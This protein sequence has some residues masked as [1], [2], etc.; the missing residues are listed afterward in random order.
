MFMQFMRWNKT[1]KCRFGIGFGDNFLLFAIAAA[2]WLAWPMYGSAANAGK[3]AP[4]IT[5][6]DWLNSRPLNA[7][8]LKGRVLLVEF[9]TYG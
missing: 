4:E 9:W 7:A 6:A 2:T 8:D 5:G 1:R 3:V